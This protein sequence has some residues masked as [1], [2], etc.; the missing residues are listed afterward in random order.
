MMLAAITKGIG[1]GI[2]GA[3]QPG[4]FQA[5]LAAESLRRGW[6]RALAC[7]LVPLI[8]DGPIIALVLIALHQIPLEMR[9]WLHLASAAVIAYL[10]ASTIARLRRGSEPAGSDPRGA[11]RSL[12]QAIVLNV[13]NPGPYVFWTLVAGPALLDAWAASAADA[14]GFLAGF[15]AALI[16][17]FCT[18]V[19]VFGTAARL[20]P[21]VSRILLA[22]SAVALAAFAL[23]ELWCGVRWGT[24]R[25]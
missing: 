11:A 24:E 10:A 15:Y 21:R 5:F 9:R 7:A 12:I 23:W 19:I 13:T 6:R 22:L 14:I 1:L 20:G 17:G 4:P 2:A 18:V 8:T 25:G 16:V 3:G